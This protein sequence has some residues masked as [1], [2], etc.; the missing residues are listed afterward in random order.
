[1]ATDDLIDIG[2][3]SRFLSGWAAEWRGARG[4]E[5]EVVEL[6]A[7]NS[8]VLTRPVTVDRPLPPYHR[9]MMDGVAVCVD[10][11]SRGKTEYCLV[12][13]RPAGDG[14]SMTLDA[15][16]AVEVMTGSVCPGEP[17]ERVIIP[18][19]R[20]LQGMPVLG[21]QLEI[22]NSALSDIVAGDFIHR[23]GV[24][25]QP[26]D[27]LVN[28][29]SRLGPAELGL[30]AS[31][32][33]SRVRVNRKI[34]VAVI[35]TGDELVDIDDQPEP[36]QIRR[37]NDVSIVAFAK[38]AGA[39]V[40]LVRHIGDEREDLAT[41]ISE[42]AALAD[43]VLISGGA[44]K[45]SRDHVPSVLS[46]RCGAPLFHGVRQRPGKPFG[47]WDGGQ[48]L[49]CAL[50]G[51]PVSVL[52]CL[53][54]HVGPLFKAMEGGWR[55][56]AK[57]TLEGEV[58][59]ESFGLLKPV[60]ELGRGAVEVLEVKNSGDFAGL[61]RMAGFVECAMTSDESADTGALDFYPLY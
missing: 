23:E 47:V 25:A 42:V 32:G 22:E 27:L 57:R 28:A 52:A 26:G 4:I 6:S 18:V 50:P 49:F 38:A 54:R 43:V 20:L 17:N 16:E 61:T 12:A 11:W 53:C 10:D 51:N 36:H 46:D 3:A 8:R 1:M 39:E 14:S 24:D 37:S 33:V 31:C 60:A 40:V 19:E 35:T 45:G 56:P 29:G 48:V 21:E 58:S 34:K 15:G 5:D 55:G 41:L 7:A 59:T 2:G 9:V 13:S 30:I 44:S